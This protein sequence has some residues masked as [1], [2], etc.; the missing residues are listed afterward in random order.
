MHCY[1]FLVKEITKWAEIFTGWFYCKSPDSC[2][3]WNHLETLYQRC[4]WALN[5]MLN[6]YFKN[7]LLILFKL[8]LAWI[9][10]E[11]M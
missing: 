3:V 4:A 6:L 1:C 8:P 7:R 2:K 5:S 11:I 9:L 10:A